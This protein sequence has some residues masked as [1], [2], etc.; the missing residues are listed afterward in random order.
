MKRDWVKR[1]FASFAFL[2]FVVVLTG[3]FSFAAPL[4]EIRAAIHQKGGRWIASDTSVSVLPDH[5]KRLRVGLM[6]HTATG[7]EPL[8]SLQPPVTGSPAS[9]DWR[10]G[11]YVTPVKDQG[12]CGSCWAFAT[13]AALES[14]AL[15][16]DGSLPTENF[17]EEVLVSCSTAGSCNGGYIDRASDFIRVTGLPPETY[18]P[19]TATSSDD[20]CTNAHQGWQT[21][22]YR[23]SSWSWVTSVPASVNA[24][25]TALSTHG[26]LVTTM[27]VYYD[28]FLYRTG[29]YEYATGS[30]QGGHAIL[31][32]GYTDD[33]TI[34]GGGYFTAKNSWGTGWGES[35]YFNIAYS[36]IG[37]PVYFGEWTIAYEQPAPPPTLPAAPSNLGATATSGSQINLTWSDNS[38]NEIGFKIERCQGAN[39]TSFNQVGTVGT[40]VT[41]YPNTG[42]TANMTYTYRVQAY[43]A[44]GNS[45]YSST[46]RATTLAPPQPPA[47]PGAL[48]A[49]PLSK[50]QMRLS[51]SDNSANESGFKVERC[52]GS[53][54][55]NFSQIASVAP[56]IST[57]TNSGLA[58]GTTYSYRVRAYNA[59]GNSA[60]SDT[61]RATTL[62]R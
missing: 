59:S 24:V 45:D 9:V 43:N 19:Y 34:H 26:P 29:V 49:T 2:A 62:Q 35:G 57:Y 46:A 15:I 55:T 47:A 1:L 52:K 51:W 32:V 28:F 23:T 41:S 14:Y 13:T 54:C 58:R 30:Y 39:C 53:T 20:T 8:L 56:N 44:A 4:D 5:E 36:Q 21:D 37:S 31:I 48:K 18:F 17:A 38:A 33:S 22:A 60:Y 12:N 3:S 61:A 16:K 25:K 42:L 11:D 40:N 27:D 50:N 7:R 6:K 10:T